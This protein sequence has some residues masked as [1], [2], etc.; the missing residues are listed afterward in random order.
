[1]HA[2]QWHVAQ[3]PPSGL[4][5]LYD[6]KK[7]AGFRKDGHNWRKKKPTYKDMKQQVQE[8]HEKLKVDG[9]YRLSCYYT[10]LAD[11][12]QFQR[13][14]YW[15]IDHPLS[16]FALVS[17]VSHRPARHITCDAGGRCTTYAAAP[18]QLRLARHRPTPRFPVSTWKRPEET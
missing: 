12:P 2:V 11:D 17:R 10:R 5:L 1:M 16:N 14:V 6:K 8:S 13:R 9:V 18:P 4:L 3:E 15:L 7:F